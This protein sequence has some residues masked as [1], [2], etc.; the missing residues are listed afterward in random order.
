MFPT[1]SGPPEPGTENPVVK[2]YN[3]VGC[4]ST[5]TNNH[6]TYGDQILTFPFGACN[7]DTN[8]DP[9]C[10]SSENGESGY[11]SSGGASLLS[12]L[13]LGSLL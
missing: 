6:T 10:W 1:Y 9:D 2:W 5:A 3:E 4:S 13:Q 12:S 11:A 8:A 7:G